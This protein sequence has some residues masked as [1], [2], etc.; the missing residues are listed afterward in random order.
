MFLYCFDRYKD[1]P[2]NNI[3]DLDDKELDKISIQLNFQYY[4]NHEFHKLSQDLKKKKSLVS[5]IITSA[6]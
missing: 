5:Y 2:G 3:I 4:Q 6:P 1:K